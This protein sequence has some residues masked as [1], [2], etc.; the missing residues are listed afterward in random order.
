MNN[1]L[2]ERQKRF[3]KE[4]IKDY[5]GTQSAIRAGYSKKSSREI[6][7][8]M[9]TKP[10]I[11]AYLQTLQ[12]KQSERLELKADFVIKEILEA[13]KLLSKKVTKKNY[14]RV[15]QEHE[16]VLDDDGKPIIEQVDALNN[17]KALDMLGKVA[18]IYEVDN[19]QKA[20]KPVINIVTAN[21]IKI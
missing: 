10:N 16:N 6:A 2:N 8:E 19:S 12:K 3:C 1:V 7:S 18:G 11:Q 13:Q 4:Y 5:N 9:L 15:L 20:D 21:N 17:L 14:N